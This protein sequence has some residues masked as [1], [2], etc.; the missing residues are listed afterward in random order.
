[1]NRRNALRFS[2]VTTAVLTLMAGTAVGQQRSLKDQLVGTW[3]V[4]SIYNLLPD[5][6]RLEANGP[7]PKGMMVFD[8]GGRFSQ[9][10]IDSTVPKYASNN[11]QRGT[12]QDFERVARGDIAYYGTYM[13]NNDQTITLHVDY[14]TYPNMDNTD[15]KRDVKLNGD[16]LQLVNRSAPSGGA[17]YLNLRREK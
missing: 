8:A 15:G 7:S 4:V 6:K 10:I 3:M 11:R 12:A 14:S 5:G 1:M 17:A 16:E 2:L 13:I 9:L